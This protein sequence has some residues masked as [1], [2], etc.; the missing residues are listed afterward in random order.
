MLSFLALLRLRFLWY[1]VLSYVCGF[2]WD[3]HWFVLNASS[4]MALYLIDL[5]LIRHYPLVPLI[6]DLDNGFFW[7]FRNIIKRQED[8]FICRDFRIL[9]TW[10]FFAT[11]LAHAH[12]FSRK[13]QD[14]HWNGH[15]G[16]SSNKSWHQA[17]RPRQSHELLQASRCIGRQPHQTS[18]R[19]HIC[20]LR[21][22]LVVF[23]AHTGATHEFVSA[24]W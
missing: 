3:F 18:S 10:H 15:H 5:C 1:S 12:F 19:T 23:L 4:S 6:S 7:L 2:F 13:T 11:D 21:F 8:T 17:K 22:D 16:L 9:V 24:L 14:T 20:G